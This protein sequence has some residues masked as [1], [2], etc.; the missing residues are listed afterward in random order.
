LTQKNA[1]QNGLDWQANKGQTVVEVFAG[2]NDATAERGKMQRVA[3]TAILNSEAQNGSLSINVNKN[4]LVKVDMQNDGK[5][6]H[7]CKFNCHKAVAQ[8]NAK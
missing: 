5:S 8:A 2:Q 7:L 1:N 6:T 4:G 3:Q